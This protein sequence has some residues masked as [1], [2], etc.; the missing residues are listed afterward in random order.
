MSVNNN[1]LPLKT[2]LTKKLNYLKKNTG[3]TFRNWTFEVII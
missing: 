2:N 3:P 1:Y